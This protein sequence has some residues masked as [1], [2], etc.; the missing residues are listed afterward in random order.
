MNNLENLLEKKER[1]VGQLEERLG[2]KFQNRKLLLE[3]MMHKSFSNELNTSYSN[4]RLEFLGDAVLGLLVGEFLMK[5]FFEDREGELAKK[6]AALVSEESLSHVAEKL[7]L[8]KFLLLGKGAQKEET[9]RRSN[10][11]DFLEAIIGAIYVDKGIR[12]VRKFVNDNLIRAR[13]PI[14]E[15]FL[16]SKSELQE[17]SLAKFRLLP[18]Y[19]IIEVS[20]PV[21][22]RTYVVTV[23][24]NGKILGTGQGKSKKNAEKDAAWKALVRLRKRGSK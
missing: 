13:T 7:D 5:H 17:Y 19:R 14:L 2:I 10:L 23:E 12:S 15:K 1:L 3:A 18:K 20:G 16:D 9:G 24:L 11:A 21:H 8:E 6:K 4:E 22:K